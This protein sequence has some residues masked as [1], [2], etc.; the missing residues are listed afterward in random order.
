MTQDVKDFADA[1]ARRRICSP[2]AAS[3][4]DAE[5]AAKREAVRALALAAVA[6]L[7]HLQCDA[8][9]GVAAAKKR[10]LTP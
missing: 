2:T 5:L 6:G 4:R 3:M 10:P 8:I 1:W 9:L 7:T